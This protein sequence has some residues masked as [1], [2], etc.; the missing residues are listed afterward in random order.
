MATPTKWG[1][2]FLVN[3]TTTSNQIYPSISMLADGRFVAMWTDNSL[4]LGDNDGDSIHGQ[5]FNADGSKAGTE[6]LVNTTTAHNQGNPKVAPLANGGFVATWN[7][8]DALAQPDVVAQIFNADGS[9][10]GAEIPVNHIAVE[11][12]YGQ[13]IAALA[14]GGFVVTFMDTS[15]FESNIVEQVYKADGT[16]LGP[17]FYANLPSVFQKSYPSVTGLTVQAGSRIGWS[18]RTRKVLCLSVWLSSMTS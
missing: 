16:E 12:Q 1:S 13:D 14:G 10:S 11:A 8:A 9:K 6:F 2:E 5:I 7:S 15:G 3:T 4:T 17:Q 18:V